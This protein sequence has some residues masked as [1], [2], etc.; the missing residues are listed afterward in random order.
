MNK[1]TLALFTTLFMAFNIP[2]LSATERLLWGH[3][4]ETSEP[5]HKWAVWAAGE[6]KQQTEG[7]VEID[8]FP[9]SILGKEAELNESL[10]LGV[11]DIIYT[12]TSFAAQLSPSLAIADLP[13]V[14]DGYSHW[15]AFNHSELLNKLAAEYAQATNGN[16]IVGNNYYGQRHVTANR[17]I[18][19]LSGMQNLKIRVPNASIFKE[20]PL[21]VGANPTP[22]A[23][24][25]VYMALQQGVV[26]AQENPLPTIKAKKFYEVQSHINLTGHL[27]GS[28]LTIVSSYRWNKLQPQD[29]KILNKVLQQAAAKVSEETRNNELALIDW[30]EQNGVTV[31][32]LDTLKFRQATLKRHAPY[33]EKVG[34]DNYQ[35]LIAL[36]PSN[37][38]NSQSGE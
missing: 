1:T 32:T 13:Y 14:F 25:E 8:I 30:F 3:V 23:F 20:F 26:D 24:S 21:A 37:Q 15:Q 22:I 34:K 12:G 4:Y 6:I 33:I 36:N 18:D 11:V 7:R 31:N 16:Q 2:V 19:D 28:I 9:I 5:L 10:S 27:L 17:A 35:A 38:S 29:R